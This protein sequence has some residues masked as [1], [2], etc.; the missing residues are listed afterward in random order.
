MRTVDALELRE[1]CLFLLDTL[2]P[3]GLVITRCGKPVAKLVP[4]ERSPSSLIG[5]LK[6]KIRICGDIRSPGAH[7]KASGG[8]APR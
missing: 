7:W 8:K 1:Q 6:V 3:E 5:S 2:E 4:I